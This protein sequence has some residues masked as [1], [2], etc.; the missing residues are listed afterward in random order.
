MPRY[1]RAT[2]TASG[3]AHNGTQSATRRAA[4][5]PL[6]CAD[7]IRSSATP[8]Y[9][10]TEADVCP[11]GKLLVGGETSRCT[12]PGRARLIAIVVSRNTRA[13]ELTAVTRNSDS[14]QRRYRA[15]SATAMTPVKATIEMVLPA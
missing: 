2:A 10:A 7:A 5:T 11:E 15:L 6:R 9:N 1:I 4:A 13:W 14:F 8:T 3:A 12:T